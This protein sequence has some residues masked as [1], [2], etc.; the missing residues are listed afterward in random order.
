LDSSGVLH[1]QQDKYEGGFT[2]A[3]LSPRGFNVPGLVIFFLIAQGIGA[4]INVFAVYKIIYFSW[5]L[6]GIGGLTIFLGLT[7]TTV[8]SNSVM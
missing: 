1:L 7:Q 6:D 2:M 4:A 8:I 3:Y 5:K